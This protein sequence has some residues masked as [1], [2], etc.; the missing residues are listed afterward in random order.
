MIRQLTPIHIG[1]LPYLHPLFLLTQKVRGS[2]GAVSQTQFPKNLTYMMLH[3]L[4]AHD[5]PRGD[6]AIAQSAGKQFKHFRF[7]RC[8]EIIL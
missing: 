3:R 7:T 2:F 5:K 6:L 4:R 8:K 1:K